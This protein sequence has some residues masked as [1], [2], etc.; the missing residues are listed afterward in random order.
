MLYSF[1]TRGYRN[2]MPSYSPTRSHFLWS[3]KGATRQA[4]KGYIFRTAAIP[5]SHSIQ[6]FSFS[7]IHNGEDVALE[8][9]YPGQLE[10][11]QLQILEYKEVNY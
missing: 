9:P 11:V 5:S 8:V 1:N 3:I 4:T 6:I 10:P 2:T 7:A